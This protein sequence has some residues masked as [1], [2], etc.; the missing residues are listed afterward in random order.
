MDV[1]GAIALGTEPPIKGS[2]GTRS[3]RREKLFSPFMW[4][5]IMGQ[6]TYQITVMM[7]L[8]YFGSMMFFEKPFNLVTEPPTSTDRLTLNTIMFYTFILMNLFNMFNCRVLDSETGDVRM[9][10]FTES[11][12]HSPMFWSVI[13]FEF[14][15]TTLM[16]NAGSSALGSALLGT[17][18][19]TT[20]QMI[21]CWSIGAFSLAVN[22]IIKKLPMQF[23]YHIANIIDLEGD[24]N[25]AWSQKINNTYNDA[26][27][28]YKRR[29]SS[30][31]DGPI[32]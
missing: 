30:V 8:M 21:I 18:G 29:L 28:Q 24:K 27:D 10:P 15:I 32:G 3:S 5:Q 31:V 14:A 17:S 13:I 7:I 1:L 12:L 16:V 2:T 19:L 11:L 25:N 26:Q 20:A 22:A 9:H 4:R 6:A 23:F